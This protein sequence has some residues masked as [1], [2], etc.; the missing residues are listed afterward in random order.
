MR[1]LLLV[2]IISLTACEKPTTKVQ[3]SSTTE[4]QETKF[5]LADRLRH[6]SISA[7]LV[8]DI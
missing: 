6:S 8:L 3:E 2:L 5:T 7:S 4:K 1:I